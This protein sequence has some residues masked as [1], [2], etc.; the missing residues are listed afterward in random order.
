[1]IQDNGDGTFL[2]QYTPEDCGPYNISITYGNEP[3]R[4]VPFHTTAVPTGDASKCRITGNAR[5]AL[6]EKTSF[7]F[8]IV[9]ISK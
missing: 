6:Y 4:G 1:M 3:V 7:K 8:S 9:V 5:T 2:V